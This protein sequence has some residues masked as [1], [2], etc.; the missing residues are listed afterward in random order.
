MLLVALGTFLLTGYLYMTIPKGFFPV[1]DTGVIQG[2]TQA[3]EA[4]SFDQMADH[5]Q[6]LAKVILTDPDVESLSSFIGVDGSNV[7]LNSGRFLIN[8][9]PHAKRTATASDIIRRIQ[10]E[11][12]NVPGIALF[13]QPVQDLS[14]D[15]AVSATQYQFTL[16]NQDLATASDLDAEGVAALEPDSL[17]RRCGQRSAA[18]RPLG[19]RRS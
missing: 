4:I 16:E 17:D 15:T 11:T 19:D 14:I 18:G 9:K 10:K 5:Q 12:A 3:A 13:M 7:T 8:L 2:V 1:Q 6:A